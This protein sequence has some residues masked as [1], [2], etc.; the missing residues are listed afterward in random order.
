MGGGTILYYVAYMLA[1]RVHYSRHATKRCPSWAST[2]DTHV[3]YLARTL[4]TII[5]DEILMKGNEPWFP[6]EAFRLPQLGVEFDSA[7]RG[8]TCAMR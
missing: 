2:F 5:E 7:L 4:P 3:Q 6:G 8:D 1:L